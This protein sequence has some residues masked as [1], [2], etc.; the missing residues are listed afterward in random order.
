M[1][2]ASGIVH[3]FTRR[4]P[5]FPLSTKTSHVLHF[6]P[7]SRQQRNEVFSPKVIH[8]LNKVINNQTYP[9]VLQGDA[10]GTSLLDCAVSF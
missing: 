8:N 7:K 3:F 2:S 9:I 6:F 4:E 5:L 1:D 10:A